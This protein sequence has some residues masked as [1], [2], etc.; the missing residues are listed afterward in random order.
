MGYEAALQAAAR[1]IR[2]TN[3]PVGLVMWT[4]RHAWV[5]SGFTSLGDPAVH[6]EFEVTGVR[7]LDPLYPHGSGRWGASPRPNALVTPDELARQFVTRTRNR[8]DYAV[9][10]SYVLVLPS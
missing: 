9:P 1:A 7:V 4:G 5:M 10:G 3:R 2:A 8:P 6:A